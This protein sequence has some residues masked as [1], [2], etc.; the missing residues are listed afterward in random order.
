MARYFFCVIFLFLHFTKNLIGIRVELDCVI[1]LD[2]S[3]FNPRKTTNM[4]ER[5]F[6]SENARKKQHAEQ[7]NN[8]LDENSPTN[9]NEQSGDEE[10]DDGSQIKGNEQ[11]DYQVRRI[12]EKFIAKFMRFV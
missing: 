1:L 9:N 5:P 2:F 7:S 3:Q 11:E 8:E 10:D 12:N 6:D 4:P